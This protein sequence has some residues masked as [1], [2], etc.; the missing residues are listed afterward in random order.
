[1]A[2]PAWRLREN[3]LQLIT[4]KRVQGNRLL[5]SNQN[6]IARAASASDG[7]SQLR[8]KRLLAEGA[9]IGW[10]ALCI[11]FFLALLTYSAE[12]AGW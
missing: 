4:V 2:S 8:S 12:D 11:I 5:S 1:M 3:P 6:K 10:L 7:E 9:M